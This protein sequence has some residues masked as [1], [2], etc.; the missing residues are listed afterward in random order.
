MQANILVITWNTQSNRL[1]ESINPET[2]K[3]HRETG[4]LWRQGAISD[5]WIPLKEKIQKESPFAVVIGF[6]EDVRPGSYFHSHLLPEEMEKIGYEFY[7]RST[8]MGIGQ[9]SVDGL[10]QGDLF[11]RGIRLSVYLQKGSR[12]KPR[13]QTESYHSS[14]F[15]N[16]GGIAVY[17]SL[18][19]DEVV[20]IINAHS[21]FE[22]NSLIETVQKKNFMIRQTAL[23]A[24][25]NFYNEMYQKL[26]MESPA[27]PQY[28]ILLGDLNYRILPFQNYS[29]G[30]TGEVLLK[31]LS[32][33]PQEY[34]L[35]IDKHDE[36]RL[37]IRKGNIYPMKEGIR[38]VGPHFAPTCKMCRE[39]S[40]GE[41]KL[42][43]YSLGKHDQRVP[44]HA[45]RILYQNLET[46]ARKLDCTEYDRFDYGVMVRSDH[47][48]VLGTYVIK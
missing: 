29:A 8:L 27:R 39:R 24:Q 25:N 5:F 23:F 40:P 35:L 22:P 44:S 15:R 20:A 31:T 11:V 3:S 9:T 42:T 6:Q 43:N 37:Q 32:E 17:L 45:D 48:G 12:I 13:Y 28:L 7:D 47:A 21:P 26:V 10:S 38:D 19:N 33:S 34:S 14:V 41:H 2:V 16:K 18:P 46:A 4:Y 30:Q 1:S 36:L